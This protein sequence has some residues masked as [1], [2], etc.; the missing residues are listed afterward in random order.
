MIYQWK[1]PNL[2]SISAQE[3]GAEIER[4]KN[5]DGFITPDA[6]VKKASD[7]ASILHSCFEWNDKEAAANYRLNQAGDLIRNIVTVSI[8]D[9]I[10]SDTP[11]RAFVNI[12]GNSERGY[13]TISTV[14]DDRDEYA[15][16]LDCAR[17]ELRAFEKK[18]G[19]LSELREVLSAI[20]KSYASLEEVNILHEKI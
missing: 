18:Y 1:I 17:S 6:V 2:Y 15:Y 10:C 14:L 13:K 7:A 11:V 4:C 3:A 8:P 9:S 20:R 5:N 19:I 16:L 12:K